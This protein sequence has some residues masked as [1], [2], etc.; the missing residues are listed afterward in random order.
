[1]ES[2]GTSR[3]KFREGDRAIYTESSTP[4]NQRRTTEEFC[5]Y[6]VQK[7]SSPSLRAGQDVL[8]VGWGDS[9]E[10]L[11][12]EKKSALNKTPI[13]CRKK[14]ESKESPLSSISAKRRNIRSTL[15]IPSRSITDI[16]KYVAEVQELS[17]NIMK[18]LSTNKIEKEINDNK[19]PMCNN[20]AVHSITSQAP[21]HLKKQSMECS[22]SKEAKNLKSGKGNLE[23]KDSSFDSILQ[24]FINEEDEWLSQALSTQESSKSLQKI[25]FVKCKSENELSF[26]QPL[27]SEMSKSL[28]NKTVNNNFRRT[29]SFDVSTGQVNLS[30]LNNNNGSGNLNKNT[31]GSSTSKEILPKPLTVQYSQQ[32]IERKRLEAIYRR[33]R[34]EIERKKMEALKRLEMK[35][36]RTIQT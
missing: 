8:E 2:P 16:A 31:I 29:S 28:P 3:A 32:E 18:E 9:P 20:Q 35:K 24:S 1:M 36:L 12:M 11:N 34:K 6:Y 22:K 33:E 21:G 4:T 25:S 17:K 26:T 13:T 30:N 5:L 7:E 14:I 27:R 23:N 10:P 19:M 15:R